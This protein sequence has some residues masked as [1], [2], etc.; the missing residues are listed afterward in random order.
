MSNH[1]HLILETPHAN[2]GDVM[3]TLL[4][5]ISKEI[6]R[7]SGRINHVFGDRYRWSILR[8]ASSAAYV[9]KYVLRNPVRAGIV[10]N[11]ENYR[12]TSWPFESAKCLPIADGVGPLWNQVPKPLSRRL[13]W[14][15]QPT[16]KEL[17]IEI[18]Q[19]LKRTYFN[20]SKDNAK[21]RAIRDLMDKYEPNLTG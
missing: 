3:R 16:E 20:F 11:L 2:L 17:E 8:T 14:L 13:A 5:G 15:N 6:Q 1:F 7:Q 12:F 4:T 18:T 19:A 9:Y 21:Q 10:N